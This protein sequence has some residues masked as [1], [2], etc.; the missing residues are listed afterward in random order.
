L[1][2]SFIDSENIK[3]HWFIIK[4]KKKT[5]GSYGFYVHS[6][7]DTNYVWTRRDNWKVGKKRN[8]DNRIVEL[9]IKKHGDVNQ[10]W[11]YTISK[12]FY[13]YDPN[14]FVKAQI[15][16]NGVKKSIQKSYVLDQA[17]CGMNKLKLV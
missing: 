10:L 12:K 1:S 13:A 14:G 2:Q 17:P 8:N 15:T 6:S 5:G 3:S 16:T 4:D 11:G 7:A 9:Q